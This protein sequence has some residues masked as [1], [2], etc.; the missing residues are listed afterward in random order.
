MVQTSGVD[1]PK[2][3]LVQKSVPCDMK[4]FLAI[5]LSSCV[6]FAWINIK[7]SL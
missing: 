6:Y 2:N 4:L 7:V 1:F 5:S 3:C